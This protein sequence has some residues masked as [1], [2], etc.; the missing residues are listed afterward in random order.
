MTSPNVHT[1]E[2]DQHEHGIAA[3]GFRLPAATRIG[4]V[5]LQIADLERSIAYY[6]GVLGFRVI[7]SRGRVAILG[8][9]DGSAAVL[10][11]SE[12]KG[13]NPVPRRSRLGL[14]HF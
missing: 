3:P 1:S 7:E 13:V 5:R 12:K 11:L 4:T 14:F 2:S 9:F 8:P 6:E 10:E